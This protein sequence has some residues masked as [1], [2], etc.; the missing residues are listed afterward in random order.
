VRRQ[1]R[2]SRPRCLHGIWH[3]CVAMWHVSHVYCIT[4]NRRQCWSGSSWLHRS[5]CFCC[6]DSALLAPLSLAP[7]CFPPC[8]S[9]EPEEPVAAPGHVLELADLEVRCAALDTL[10]AAPEQPEAE[11]ISTYE[12]RGLRWAALLG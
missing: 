11:L 10:M 5:C 4:K 6:S 1:G 8:R 7:F 2:R 12:T 9:L 3:V